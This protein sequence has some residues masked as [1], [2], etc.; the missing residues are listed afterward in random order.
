MKLLLD[1]NISNR[2]IPKLLK[3]FPEVKHVKDYGLNNS[4]DIEI[5]KFAKNEH[6]IMVTFDSD[7]YDMSL[8]YGSPPKIIWIRTGNIKT[9]TLAEILI[10]N[11]V[12][13]ENIVIQNHYSCLTLLDKIWSLDNQNLLKY[14]AKGLMVISMLSQMTSFFKAIFREHAEL[15]KAIDKHEIKNLIDLIVIKST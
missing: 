4:N 15:E 6:R 12:K 10:S 1:Q 3:H 2:I 13:I 14:P 11:K 8:I 9:N 5:W 7:F